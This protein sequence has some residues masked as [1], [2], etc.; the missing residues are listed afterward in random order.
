MII[1]SLDYFDSTYRAYYKYL[2]KV[3]APIIYTLKCFT[4]T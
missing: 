1:K 2:L 4:I 3:F